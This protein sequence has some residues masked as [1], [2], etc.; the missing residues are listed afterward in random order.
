MWTLARSAA[1]LQPPKPLAEAVISAEFKLPMLL[2]GDASLWSSSPSLIDTRTGSAR[3][4]RRQTAFARP[5]SMDAA[6]NRP[7]VMTHGPPS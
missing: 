4:G 6:M 1:A 2:P 5:L 3:R 7:P